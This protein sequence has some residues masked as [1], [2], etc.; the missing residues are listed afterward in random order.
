MRNIKNALDFLVSFWLKKVSIYFIKTAI[1]AFYWHDDKCLLKPRIPKTPLV[2]LLWRYFLFSIIYKHD[3]FSNVFCLSWA[4][5]VMGWNTSLTRQA[6]RHWD[7]MIGSSVTRAYHNSEKENKIRIITGATYHDIDH[8][9][10]FEGKL[11]L[12]VQPNTTSN[13]MDISKI[14]QCMFL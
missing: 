13:A 1:W 9:F 4:L 5:T 12:T 14:E 10:L 6:W 3:K 8:T 7:H 2:A 11:S